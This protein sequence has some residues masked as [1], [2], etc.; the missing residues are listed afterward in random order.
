[1]CVNEGDDAG[2]EIFSVALSALWNICTSLP[3]PGRTL[4]SFL[5]FFSAMLVWPGWLFRYEVRQH[6]AQAYFPSRSLPVMWLSLGRL[7]Q[8]S[9]W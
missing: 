4:A 1:M 8:S 3:G 5:P 6:M 2:G 7:F 9:K